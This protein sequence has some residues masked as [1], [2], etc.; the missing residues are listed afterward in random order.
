MAAAGND[1]R[2]GRYRIVYR[3]GVPVRI[4]A[5]DSDPVTPPPSLRTAA[6]QRARKFAGDAKKRVGRGKTQEQVE[7]HHARISG[8]RDDS[9]RHE[10]LLEAHHTALFDDKEDTG[11]V[12]A[13]QKIEELGIDQAA[14]AQ[15]FKEAQEGGR[16]SFIQALRRHH[17]DDSMIRYVLD[18]IDNE[19]NLD[20]LSDSDLFANL[21]SSFRSV[22]LTVQD[23]AMSRVGHGNALYGSGPWLSVLSAVSS[24]ARSCLP[25]TSTRRFVASLFTLG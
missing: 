22:K 10:T 2:E 18:I 23:L 14:L 19:A 25:R 7:Q 24:S 15:A 17:V 21:F 8:L 3:D 13:H 16:K 4:P 1:P 20:D 12:R 9:T 6:S 11:L 5:T